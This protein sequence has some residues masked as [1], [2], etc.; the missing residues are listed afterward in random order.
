[1]AGGGGPE[2][3]GEAVVGAVARVGRTHVGSR[4]VGGDDLR[5][6]V[7]VDQHL[8]GRGGVGVDGPAPHAD[9]V[10]AVSLLAALGDVQ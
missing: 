5:L 4:L 8:Y 9:R 2:H 6:A 1:M 3:G 7:D 10:A